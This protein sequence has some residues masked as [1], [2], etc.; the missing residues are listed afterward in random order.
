[1]IFTVPVYVPPRYVL[2][3][4]C[5]LRSPL[6][7]AYLQFCYFALLALLLFVFGCLPFC[8]LPGC[9]FTRLV[10]RSFARLYVADTH[11]FYL[12]PCTRFYFYHTRL[13]TQFA[14]TRS[15]GYTRLLVGYGFWLLPFILP[16][17]QLRLVDVWFTPFTHTPLQLPVRLHARFTHAHAVHVLPFWFCAFT[18]RLFC[19]LHIYIFGYVA[20]YVYSL[21]VTPFTHVR[22]GYVWL[23]VSFTRLVT[24]RLLFYVVT[25]RYG[26]FLYTRTAHLYTVTLVVAFTRCYSCWLRLFFYVTVLP[27]VG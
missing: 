1:M 12:T 10:L 14:R 6:R 27:Y 20:F 18:L 25:V 26:W 19:I 17:F 9:A 3:L 22:F 23:L 8:R 2:R 7:L 4:R 13:V 5:W 16:T 15:F 11:T 24:L 21:V